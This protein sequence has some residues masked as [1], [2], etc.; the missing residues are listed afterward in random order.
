M[1][2]PSEASAVVPTDAESPPVPA[3]TAEIRR[4]RASVAQYLSQRATDAGQIGAALGVSKEV[5]EEDIKAVR[6]DWRRGRRAMLEEVGDITL[7][8]LDTDE[9]TM[10]QMLSEAQKKK[11]VGMSIRI[12][13]MIRD[14]QKL[15][16][17]ISGLLSAEGQQAFRSGTDES[18]EGE[19]GSM[20]VFKL[21]S[22][23]VEGPAGGKG[24]AGKRS[25][26]KADG[27][28]V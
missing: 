13:D 27:V 23:E 20:G 17:Q 14:T 16:L 28:A 11:E 3:V 2:S 5:V 19:D 6:G 10:R 4:R 26:P 24:K 12:L 7:H 15:R 25:S 22:S 21:Y 9:L 1:D 18:L 8:S